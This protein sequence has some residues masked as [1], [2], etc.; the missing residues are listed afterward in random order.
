[1]PVLV[2][3]PASVLAPQRAPLF[4]T[5]QEAVD[6]ANSLFDTG[7]VPASVTITIRPATENEQSQAT[8]PFNDGRLCLVLEWTQNLKLT[9]ALTSN[10]ELSLPVNFVELAGPLLAI[11]QGNPAGPW[12]V[13]CAN[14][15]AAS[16]VAD[17]VGD[18]EK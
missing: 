9:G 17:L 18:V 5:K 1:M 6:V 14:I 12:K 16:T 10:R 13:F 4:V 3:I 2:N 7:A 8:N 15:A 11:M